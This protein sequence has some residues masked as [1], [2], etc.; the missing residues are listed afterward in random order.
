[1]YGA[2]R[3]VDQERVWE[4]IIF[5]EEGTMLSFL[6]FFFFC[7]GYFN[8][9]HFQN[10]KQ[11]LLALSECQTKAFKF[12]IQEC[13]LMGLTVKG[14]PVTWSNWRTKADHVQERLDQGLAMT[15]WRL[16]VPFGHN[17]A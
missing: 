6:L 14:E 2:S 11:G 8:S 16:N 1:M 15:K 7:I 3:E 17:W 5:G 10:E 12:F 9:Y 13:C 4:D